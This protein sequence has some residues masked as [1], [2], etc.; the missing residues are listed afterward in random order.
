MPPQIGS[1]IL[2]SCGRFQNRKA[3]PSADKG[4]KTQISGVL[5]GRGRLGSLTRS[6][7]TAIDTM[8]KANRVPEFEMSAS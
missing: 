4:A 7:S 2:A 3:Q 8:K 1:T 6:T 5:N